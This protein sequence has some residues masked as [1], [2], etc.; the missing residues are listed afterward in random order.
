MAPKLGSSAARE[1][2]I[3]GWSVPRSIVD[4]ERGLVT[5]VLILEWELDWLFNQALELT[6]AAV[7]LLVLWGVGV[8]G[9]G[10]SERLAVGSRLALPRF[11]GTMV[12]WQRIWEV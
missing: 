3:E 2:G 10:G 9:D 4:G 11:W 8:I 1:I 5:S 7:S 12:Y 6:V